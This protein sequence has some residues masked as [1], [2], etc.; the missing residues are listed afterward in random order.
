MRGR[1]ALGLGWAAVL[2]GL[3]AWLHGRETSALR[4]ELV[5]LQ[6][7]SLEIGFVAAVALSA[8]VLPRLLRGFGDSSRTFL[9]LGATTA[10]G[11]VLLTRV[12]ER[13]PRIFFDEQ[14][15][16]SIGQNLADEKKAWM[17]NDGT[18]EYGSVTCHRGEYNKQPYGYPYLLSLVFRFAGAN[19]WAGWLVNNLCLLLLPWTVYA[20]SRLLFDD[21]GAAL[22]AA[23]LAVLVP[24]PLMWSNTSSSETSAALAVLA[25]VAS[26]LTFVRQRSTAALAWT[27]A[28]TSFAL[29]FRPESILV[30]PLV[31]G[32]LLLLAPRELPRRRLLAAALGG[33]VL[34]AVVLGHLVAVSGES[35]GVTDGPRMS[36]GYFL[37]NLRTNGLFYFENVRFPVLYT[38]LALLG[39]FR[40]W[41]REV[42]VPVAHFLLFWGV[43]LFFYAGSYDYGADV[44]YSLLS[45]PP[46]ALLAGRG[47]S[48]LLDLVPTVRRTVA[49][50]AAVAL[51]AFNF[52]AF[53]PLVRAAGEE[54]WAARA[55]VEIARQFRD[56]LPADSVVLTHNPNMF[57]VWGA[58]AAQASYGAYEDGYVE[59]YLMTRYS[60]GV[61]FH[62]NYW[63]N[64]QVEEQSKVCEEILD[65]FPAELVDERRVRDQ[66]FALYRLSLPGGKVKDLEAM[67]QSSQPEME[68]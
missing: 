57:L 24:E 38:V 67:E 51:V 2:A 30:L 22:W 10:L 58:N 42:L 4:Q 66:R 25:A 26:A 34:S 9:L 60:G 52:L 68:P 48:G 19:D 36:A 39:V 64:A 7:Y 50:R 56:R 20:V 55:G 53:L 44:R 21:R 15:Y 45:Y 12:V 17:C 62:W 41:R 1:L 59:D 35:W 65:R 49:S 18:T 47:L 27:V 28:T 31:G 63:C 11:L 32:I 61:F 40:A 13:T 6:F 46:L 43:F 23:L 29:Q 8:L 33:L 3:Y 16:L 37:G 54:A 14:I 5:G